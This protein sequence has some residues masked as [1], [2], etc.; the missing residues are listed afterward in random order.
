[1][2]NFGKF[3]SENTVIFNNFSPKMTKVGPKYVSWGSI[4]ADTVIILTSDRPSW[5]IVLRDHSIAKWTK[6]L[7]NNVYI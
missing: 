3:S 5:T 2:L 4:D 6:L 1:M 7:K